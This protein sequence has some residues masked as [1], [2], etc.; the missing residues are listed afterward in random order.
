MKRIMKLVP[1]VLLLAGSPF[2]LTAQP[3][4]KKTK[5][6]KESQQIIITRNADDKDKI[7]VE[8]NE[9]GVFI[10]GK[11][12]S[13]YKEGD[14]KVMTKKL[15][16]A[17]SLS[18]NTNGQVWNMAPGKGGVL[19]FSSVDKDRAML[20]VGTENNEK[21]AEVKSITKESAAEK[22]GLKEGDIITKLDDTKIEN[23][24]DLSEVV[25]KHKPG[26]KVKVTWLREGKEQKA[27]AELTEWKGMDFFSTA[28]G[29]FKIQNFNADG[30]NVMP[31]MKQL[32]GLER[33]EMPFGQSWSWA[34]NGP[35]L[36]LS[37][38]DTDDGKGV[39]VIEVDEESNAAKAGIKEND[40]IIAIDDKEVN[41][42]DAVVKLIRDNKE[43][44]PMMV[45]LI[46]DGKTINM[47][48]KMPRKLKTADL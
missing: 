47:E 43:K 38:Q 23:P 26:D 30:M 34:G 32:E 45:K 18:I 25:T 3:A 2:L 11:P 9:K 8:I 28:P 17:E 40:I 20:G 21:G 4:E 7:V 19:S 48:V 42:T 15:K 5:E 24:E 22:I 33:M 29:Q 41:S 31:R 6:K 39:K 13:E 10:N 14:I 35:K 1:V 16:D 44:V 37:V 12:A 36:G 27:T 46:R